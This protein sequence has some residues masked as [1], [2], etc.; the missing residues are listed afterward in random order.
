V[1]AAR[2]PALA[3]A[4]LQLQLNYLPELGH[5]EKALSL[6]PKVEEVAARHGRPKEK[7]RV[8]WAKARLYAGIGRRHESQILLRRVQEEFW[9]MAQPISAAAVTLEMA[10]LYFQEGNLEAVSQLAEEIYPVF[11]DQHIHREALAALALFQ[12]AALTDQITGTLL[13]ELVTYFRKAQTNPSL[14]FT[15]NPGEG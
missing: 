15:L 3:L 8:Q 11:R 13:T 12:Q 7:L 6:L 1:D 9:E 4:A 10:T 2:D 14:R 5:F